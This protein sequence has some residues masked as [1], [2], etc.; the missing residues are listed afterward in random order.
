MK[1]IDK[2]LLGLLTV[3]VFTLTPTY[4]AM[5]SAFFQN[6]IGTPS[7]WI[8][9]GTTLSPTNND[10]WTVN[11]ATLN[12]SSFVDGAMTVNG[13][14]LIGDG[15]GVATT[16]L[17][18]EADAD[19]VITPDT[20]GD[21]IFGSGNVGVG[22]AAPAATNK[23]Q[24]SQTSTS[25]GATGLASSV[26]GAVTGS[27][28]GLYSTVSGAS[29][30]NW[31]LYVAA[32]DAYVDGD[33]G[34]GTTGPASKLHLSGAAT[35]DARITLTQTTA[36]VTGV[37]QQGSTALDIS[38]DNTLP[39]SVT[40]GGSE[41]MR[42]DTSGN[43]GIGATS[44]S[45]DVGITRY[46]H[47]ENATNAGIVLEDT[48]TGQATIWSQAGELKFAPG[49]DQLALIID[50][51]G[52]VGVGTANPSAITG[53]ASTHFHVQ[54]D[55]TTSGSVIEVGRFE[56]GLDADGS[57][58]L[59]RINTSNDRGLYLEGGRTG[60]VQYGALGVTDAAGA[61]TEAIRIDNTG[62]VGIGTTS[63]QGALSLY[64]SSGFAEINYG[65]SDGSDTGRLVLNG[66]GGSFS[67]GRGAGIILAGN[68][69]SNYGGDLRL[70]S[71]SGASGNILFSTPS[72]GDSMVI[73]SSGNVGIGTTNPSEKLEIFGTTDAQM[74]I[75]NSGDNTA[76]IFLDSNRTSANVII[77]QTQ[78]FW[79]GTGVNSIDLMSGTDTT[80][81][82]DGWVRFRT[83]ES[84]GVITERFRIE[85]A[86]EAEFFQG[87]TADKVTADPCGGAG[88]SEGSQF[89][90]DTSNY[91]C[92][93][94]G[95]NDVQM[96]SP[97]T[98]CF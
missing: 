58:A 25:N 95:T 57:A 73:Y 26:S 3:S 46:L 91:Y 16:T 65:T 34:I 86:G 69:N 12:V 39:F 60:V 33:V 18:T 75:D 5:A 28:Y 27:S 51:T 32:G 47:I 20:G 52:N 61:K 64:D 90:N 81:K 4:F 37:I 49:D 97:A 10:D 24:I 62:K 48:G 72:G 56:G 96:H 98:A 1:K 92:Y 71:G 31:G 63:P 88:Y 84:G 13:N 11:I 42:V 83:R 78:G 36:G 30:A 35:A 82:D 44:I 80:N 77:G 19:F 6:P 59:V 9:D 89:Y 29:V 21:T 50:A 94:D 7:F 8:L 87:L 66:G 22:V 53:G 23:V 70:F 76:Q 79:N 41:S 85:A 93:C 67:N 40:T 14:V 17:D 15:T 2:F 74:R 43:V 38:P 45:T 55:I 54:G 68:E